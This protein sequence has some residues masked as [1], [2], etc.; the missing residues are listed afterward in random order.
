MFQAKNTPAMMFW[1]YWWRWWPYT[2]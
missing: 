1:N 2:I